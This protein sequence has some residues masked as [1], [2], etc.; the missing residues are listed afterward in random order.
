MAR[1]HVTV[2]LSGDGGDEAFLGY[3][4]YA[5]VLSRS[6]R[7][8]LPGPFKRL[9]ATLGSSLPEGV[10]GRRYLESF[11]IADPRYFCVGLSESRKQRLFSKDFL[12]AVPGADTFNIY[13]PYLRGSGEPLTQYGYLDTKVYL[14][15]NVLVKVDRMS[16]AHSLEARTLFLDHKIVE[17]AARIPASL[18][19]RNGMS[20]YILKKSV[21]SL[22]PREILHRPK[23]G[24]ALP[25]D[26]WLRGPLK[27]I[28]HDAVVWAGR[29]GS[30]DPAYA[31]RL[32]SDHESGRCNNQRLLWA[33]MMFRMWHEQCY[34]D[35]HRPQPVLAHS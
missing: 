10:I 26:V 7:H 8:W 19:L 27:D 15:D 5:S 29:Q 4:S 34:S 6:N 22:L 9:A 1:E 12:A 33:L 31:S 21:E 14:P 3:D 18:K 35:L 32:L 25:T 20:K 30:F 2:V 13:Q 16:M 23:S 24:F 28:M 11:G 17:F